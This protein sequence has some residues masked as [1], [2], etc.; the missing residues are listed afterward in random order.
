M[1]CYA[2]DER[3]FISN[4]WLVWK[5]SRRLVVINDVIHQ[6]I[7]S[8]W[9]QISTFSNKCICICMLKSLLLACLVRNIVAQLFLHLC[10]LMSCRCAFMLVLKFYQSIKTWMHWFS[11]ILYIKKVVF[12]CNTAHKDRS[13]ILNLKSFLNYDMFLF[14]SSYKFLLYLT[15][16]P[17]NG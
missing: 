13:G 9:L 2:N 3:L 7:T 8:W 15:Y 4:N 11:F 12:Q 17:E 6:L 1:S 5:K 14:Q 16:C 10:T